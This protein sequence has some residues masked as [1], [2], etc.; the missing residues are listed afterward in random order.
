MNAGLTENRITV[1]LRGGDLDVQ[2]D[3]KGILY[4]TGTATEV[5]RG[6]YNWEE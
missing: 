6:T 4:L 3:K 1:H 2:R 5:F